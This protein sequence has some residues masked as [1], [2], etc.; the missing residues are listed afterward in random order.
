MRL[1]KSILSTLEMGTLGRTSSESQQC[2]CRMDF[3]T[4]CFAIHHFPY[5][6]SLPFLL[7]YVS[8]LQFTFQP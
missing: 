2:P 6:T 3:Q 8:S 1:L 7:F 4:S 5:P